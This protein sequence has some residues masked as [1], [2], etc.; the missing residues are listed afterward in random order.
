MR[1]GTFHLAWTLLLM[2]VFIGI[3]Y[4]AWS[5]RRRK[6]FGEAAQLPLEEDGRDPASE[7]ENGETK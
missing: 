7:P 3:V 2:A 1:D 6:D 5:S 4:R